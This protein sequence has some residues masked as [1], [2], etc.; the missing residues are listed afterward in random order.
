MHLVG[1]VQ[2][3]CTAAAATAA[4][5]VAAA[6]VSVDS[7]SWAQDTDHDGQVVRVTILLGIEHNT[8]GIFS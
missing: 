3:Q 1:P 8:I 2:R 5:V 7:G 6:A 4:A